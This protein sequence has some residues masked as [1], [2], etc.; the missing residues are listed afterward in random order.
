MAGLQGV[1]TLSLDQD[2][3]GVGR[4]ESTC[5]DWSLLDAECPDGGLLQRVQ[6]LKWGGRAADLA[7]RS[8][9]RYEPRVM[10]DCSA[11]DLA[12]SRLVG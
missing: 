2:K 7:S 3:R 6:I 9:K 1:V 10:W 8:R 11:L 5:R 4:I 12:V